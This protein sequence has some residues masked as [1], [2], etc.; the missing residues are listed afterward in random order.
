MNDKIDLVSEE[1]KGL[2]KKHGMD[3]GFVLMVSDGGNASVVTHACTPLEL[4]LMATG[5]LREATRMV[6]EGKLTGDPE[7]V[8]E[9]SKKLI[10]EVLNAVMNN[11]ALTQKGAGKEKGKRKKGQVKKGE[12]K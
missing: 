11:V 8:A 12:S 2:L 4:L 9:G 3:E 5:M 7:K 10:D 6:C 1:L